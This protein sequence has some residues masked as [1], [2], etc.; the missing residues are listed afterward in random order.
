MKFAISADSNEVC[1]HFGRAPQFSFVTIEDNK[2]IKTELLNNP[3][4]T[5]GSLPKFI[6]EQGAKI[7]ITGGMG[8]RAIDFFKKYGIE[9]VLGVTG[10]IDDVI[11]KIL[12]GTLE[13]GESL[14]FP[15]AGKGFGVEKIHTEADDE[16]EH[17]HTN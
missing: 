10:K 7:I 6:N 11:N 15:G 16:H 12:A 5:I 1:P 14:C 9:V 8:R 13:G 4:H 17:H 2:V 3:G